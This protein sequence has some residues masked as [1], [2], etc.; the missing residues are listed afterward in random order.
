MDKLCDV[1]VFQHSAIQAF[2]GQIKIL[3]KQSSKK[4]LPEDLIM[5]L[6]A[7]VDMVCCLD[8]VKDTKACLIN[9]FTRYKRAMSSAGQ[10]L[11]E[12]SLAHV[13]KFLGT[14]DVIF[15][16]LIQAIKLVPC[17]E[18]VILQMLLLA[19][20]RLDSLEFFTPQSKWCTIRAIPCLL[21]LLTGGEE[22]GSP[23]K[24]KK[25]KLSNIQKAL[26]RYPAV[27]VYG[28]LTMDLFS[29]LDKKVPGF[30]TESVTS[31]F[32]AACHDTLPSSYKLSLRRA[33]MRK[34]FDSC[35]TTLSVT[36]RT[37][38]ATTLEKSVACSKLAKMLSL[39]VLEALKILT[40]WSSLV[41]EVVAWKYSH[42]CNV[43]SAKAQKCDTSSEGAA[44]ERVLRYNLDAEEL[45]SL[46]ECVTLVK[47]LGGFLLSVE[48]SLAPWIRLYVS[49][50][51]QHLAQADLV[52]ILHRADKKKRGVMLH[53]LQLRAMV[54]DW[55][56]DG[57]GEK[58]I[59]L[60]KTYK[61]A[62]GRVSF[63][64]MPRLVGPS[65]T[66]LLLIRAIVSSM[67]QDGS[68]LRQGSGVLGK[69]DLKKEDVEALK[70]FFAESSCF[71][72]LCDLGVNVHEGMDLSGL[73]FR[74]FFLELT[75][76]IQ[77]PIECSLP[78]L[79]A[80]HL[81]NSRD[82]CS[83]AG[84]GSGAG[85]VMGE[86]GNRGGEVEGAVPSK[87]KRGRNK[88]SKGQGWRGLVEEV[89][90]V[91]DIYSDAGG[92]ALHDLNSRHLITELSSEVNLV[93][94]QLIFYWKA[95]LYRYCKDWAASTQL[96]KQFKR[97]IE[98]HRGFG[99][100]CPGFGSYEVRQHVQVMG[101][102]VDLTRR[103]ALEMRGKVAEDLEM[104]MRKFESSDVSGIIELEESTGIVHLTN[105]FL[106]LEGWADIQGELRSRT[107]THVL[108]S[109]LL[110]LFSAWR[111]C[112][113]SQ[114][115]VP[116]PSRSHSYPSARNS[117]DKNLGAGEV[118]GRGFEQVFSAT[119]GF[120]GREHVKSLMTV[121]DPAELALLM[122]TV[123]QHVAQK[124]GDIQS[125]TVPLATELCH[126][127]FLDISKGS[128]GCYAEVEQRLG[129]LLHCEDLK[130]GTFQDFR[131]LG[132]ALAILQLLSREMQTQDWVRYIHAAPVIGVAGGNKWDPQRTRLATAVRAASLFAEGE[133]GG[134]GAKQ[135]LA[136][137]SVQL[138]SC[139][140][141]CRLWS[142]NAT[143]LW[144]HTVNKVDAALDAQN[145]RFT[146][147]GAQADNCVLDVNEDYAF[148]RMY[149]A[150]L[151]LFCIPENTGPGREQV[152]N[153]WVEFGDGFA[154]AGS[155]IMHL[156]QQHQ[157]FELLDMVG[158]VLSADQYERGSQE[159]G[160]R[161]GDP[162]LQKRCSL[163]LN[164]AYRQ[165]SLLHG[166]R[167]GLELC[168]FSAGKRES[169]LFHPPIDEKNMNAVSQTS[170]Q[171]S[172]S[173]NPSINTS[174]STSSSL[175]LDGGVDPNQ[176]RH[177]RR[178]T[179]GEMSV[180]GL[181]SPRVL[182]S[183]PRTPSY[184][185][186]G[187]ESGKDMQVSTGGSGGSLTVSGL[188][189][190][191]LA[192][193]AAPKPGGGPPRLA[194]P[195]PGGSRT[196]H[197]HT[198]SV[199]HQ[200][201]RTQEASVSSAAAARPVSP[202]R[203]VSSPN[204]SL[205]KALPSPPMM[206]D[207]SADASAAA[208]DEKLNWEKLVAMGFSAQVSA[209]AL[210]QA[211]GDVNVAV[212]MLLSDE[213]GRKNESLAK[214][215]PKVGA[216]P[217][218]RKPG[219]SQA[220]ISLKSTS[221]T[222]QAGASPKPRMSQAGASPN[223]AFDQLTPDVLV[224]ALPYNRRQ[225]DTALVSAAATS[226]LMSSRSP[227]AM[228]QHVASPVTT[229]PARSRRQSA[230]DSSIVIPG[231]RGPAPRGRAPAP[232]GAAPV[233]GGALPPPREKAAAPRSKPSS[234][235][236]SKPQQLVSGLGRGDTVQQQPV[237]AGRGQV[238]HVPLQMQAPGM[239]A[240]PSQAMAQQQQLHL[241]T[242]VGR[243]Q[244]IRPQ[245]QQQGMMHASMQYQ[246]PV[247]TGR[248]QVPHGIMPVGAPMG[249]LPAPLQSQAH[250]M[251]A[252]PSVP[253][254]QLPRPTQW[255]GQGSGQ[256][257]V[258]QQQQQ[259]QY[260]SQQIA[261]GRG[262]G[263]MSQQ[264]GMVYQQQHPYQ[265]QQM[266]MQQ[267]MQRA[268]TVSTA[269]RGG[270]ISSMLFLPGQGEING[271]G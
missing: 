149:S 60:Y 262:L 185:S 158:S 73:W 212:D 89:L 110:D 62:Q 47:S 198:A 169:L 164:A 51:V 27:P 115:F 152:V 22:A 180:S 222:S 84:S 94:D 79:L 168:G 140:D 217:K 77:F 250:G 35:V 3:A 34:D 5:Q 82:G 8:H 236:S 137:L 50:S 230:P 163:F 179:G 49:S 125:W 235:P 252:A 74:E 191:H 258:Q 174:T 102:E 189:D 95:H 90:C 227:Q 248:G 170:S 199:S 19:M 240:A 63:E 165:R 211:N 187:N 210:K 264:Q 15:T 268:G 28:D 141:L 213:A 229:L 117:M 245:A 11:D 23:F 231:A 114:R 208:Q 30:D 216:S 257:M 195:M 37:L 130:S 253:G 29:F 107:L 256:T 41:Q 36:I 261:M 214:G 146:W 239:M 132:N 186:K 172:I 124:L 221:L 134:K 20:G 42:P 238:P 96:D 32:G 67:Y 83:G 66:Q 39:Q 190:S 18:E 254:M 126:A 204:V 223:P 2:A 224:P 80:D 233:G 161:T 226:G 202:A 61:R 154:L 14:K 121:L 65:A 111:F 31:I 206:A 255:Q 78:W 182:P 246:Q 271:Q 237:M 251:V 159:S 160:P 97:S 108:S 24:T 201:A 64:C 241:R 176:S 181:P 192:R 43:E 56:G 122:E 249:C 133:P 76:C 157:K 59:N 266:Q 242:A 1:V 205:L 116:C 98:G 10:H 9:D 118:C 225:S 156:L 104:A 6:S 113:V 46:V 150:L 200:S 244:E 197:K 232:R 171:T 209:S 106:G 25:I 112:E 38:A 177:R 53:L 119:R 162:L 52:P 143:S 69:G 207:R 131:Q 151:F 270:A 166:M 138:D 194:A 263:A 91:L 144:A 196:L 57:E 100:Y 123:L 54:A 260:Q 265:V 167:L 128:T 105:S 259:Y 17:H 21:W 120:F 247:M 88:R 40:Q 68:E 155:V 92:A 127:P 86:G 101:R 142:T 99:W 16:G 173:I 139:Q 33:G 184:K 148:F 93:F 269:S 203:R 147:Q 178:S 215:P 13:Q 26:H 55:S 44:F 4:V 129:N 175:Q 218:L 228:F 188:P 267:Q 81:M 103:F 70:A 109:L 48:A 71:G 145:L 75:Q 87:K 234:Q 243:G 135:T 183:V 45:R 85:T 58:G 153:D 193:A 219:L 72:V 7:V 220:G 12:N 136:K